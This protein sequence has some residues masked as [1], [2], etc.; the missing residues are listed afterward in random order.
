MKVNQ[1]KTGVILSYVSMF[2]SN[3]IAIVYTPIMLRILGRSEYGLYTLVNSVVGYLGLLSFGFDST[4]V[5]YF[6]V[7]KARGDN[8]TTAKLNGMFLTVFS[9]IAAITVIA[10]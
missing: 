1:L 2:L 5:R 4:Y 8:E 3:I 10:G 6:S 7:Y 9:A